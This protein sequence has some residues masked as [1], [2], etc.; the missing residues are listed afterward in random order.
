MDVRN[1]TSSAK[2]A[3]V[4]HAL[5]ARLDFTVPR[6]NSSSPDINQQTSLK[7]SLDQRNLSLLFVPSSGS[8]IGLGTKSSS[9][10]R[11][12]QTKRE[13]KKLLNVD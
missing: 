5:F 9:F 10:L 4:S 11:Q 12:A 2:F 6:S 8:D 13:G 7:H 1:H 3:G